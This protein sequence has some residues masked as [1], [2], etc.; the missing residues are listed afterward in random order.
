MS[1]DRF[2]LD[3]LK[4]SECEFEENRDVASFTSSRISSVARAIAYPESEEK[5][6]DL[7]SRLNDIG[8]KHIV[9][10]K[11]SNVLIKNGKY[12]G[13]IVKTHKIN[14]YN[15][16]ENILTLSCG[17]SLSG[18]TQKMVAF[19]LGGMEGLIGI[20]GTVGGMVRQNAGAFG[21]EIADRFKYAICYLTTTQNTV[22]L[23]KDDMQFAYRDSILA[24]ARATLISA[25]FELIPKRRDDVV[26]EI[27]VYRIKRL[28]TQPV[29]KP[30]LGCVFKRY[31]GVSAGYYIDK[32]GLKGCSVGGACVSRK[33]AGFI[34]NN[35]GATATDYLSLIEYVKERVFH[36]FNI[37]LEEEIEII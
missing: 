12:D 3:V 21:Y 19:D 34:V 23:S 35:G 17:A 13:V 6:V 20:P 10:G 36:E 24:H 37:E 8:A 16:A 26:D 33:H 18:A 15:L 1:S 31:N 28:E 2:F 14:K 5:L 22:K 4:K 9:L 30:S 32:A 25:T 11:M 27:N 29:T 7:I